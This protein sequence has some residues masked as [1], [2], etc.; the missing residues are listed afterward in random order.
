MLSVAEGENGEVVVL[1]CSVAEKVCIGLQ[2]LDYVV[3]VIIVVC[4]YHLDDAVFTVLFLLLVFGFVEAVGVEQHEPVV[5]EVNLFA[6]EFQLRPE[7]DGGICFLYVEERER[8]VGIA[9]HGR[10]VSGIAILHSSEFG[11]E[12]ADEH[13]DEHAGLVVFR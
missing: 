11:V 1:F 2:C 13:G 8:S 6:L 5:E 3:R 12:H 9:N 7:S 10:I 4:G